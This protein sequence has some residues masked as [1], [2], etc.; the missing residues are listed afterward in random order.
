MTLTLRRYGDSLTYTAD[1][2]GLGVTGKHLFG[3]RYALRFAYSELRPDFHVF[4]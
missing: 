3:S 1:D 4:C 2:Q